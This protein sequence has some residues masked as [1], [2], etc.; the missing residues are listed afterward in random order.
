LTYTLDPVAVGALR[1]AAVHTATVVITPARATMSPVSFTITLDKRLPEITSVGPYV[2]LAGAPLRV[3][4]RGT[5]FDAIAS[6]PARLSLEG[7]NITSAERVNDTEIVVG[8]DALSVG[9]H[10]IAVSNAAALPAPHS[11][12]TVIA[13]QAFAAASLPTGGVV[14]SL[15]FDAERG[16]VYAANRTLESVMSFTASGATWNVDS[17]PFANAYDVGLSNDGKNLIAAS[18]VLDPPATGTGSIRLLDPATLDT[19]STTPLP[20]GLEPTFT[21]RG[22][23]IHTTNDG[24]S[25]LAVGR[26]FGVMTW[27]RADT[28]E[29]ARV[30]PPFQTL[31]SGGPWFAA[32]RDGERLIVVQGSH[33]EP[34][35]PLLYLDA[36][37]SVL[38]KNPAN[39]LRST[40]LGLNEDGSRLLLESFRGA[41]VRDAGFNLVGR[42][43]LPVPPP[44][45]PG[46]ELRSAVISVDGGRVY[47]LAYPPDFSTGTAGPR[48]FVFDSSA[49][50]AGSEDL[51]ALGYFDVPDY[52]TCRTGIPCNSSPV[53]AA[54]ALDAKTLFFGGDERLLVVPIPLESTLSPLSAPTTIGAGKSAQWR[55][56][57]A[58]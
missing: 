7:G 43:T 15:T 51:P 29:L 57:R 24:R 12:V 3:I 54:I 34:D 8:A 52:P 9:V 39:L 10:E 40:L 23:G 26:Q 53:A 55:L 6:V 19:L 18:N 33:N 58:E 27:F 32:S 48:V 4:L 56:E 44:F 42:A 49:Q 13:P 25:W 38:K 14:P 1:N 21:F 45:Q 11:A 31:F 20:G 50:P 46:Y 41:E 22:F 2:H 47:L 30:L 5:G 28:A 37:D 36:A 35:F 17:V 16:A